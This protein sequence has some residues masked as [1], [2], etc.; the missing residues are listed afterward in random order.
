MKF[1]S[2]LGSIE[3][4]LI[5]QRNKI[6]TFNSIRVSSSTRNTSRISKKLFSPKPCY[7]LFHLSSKFVNCATFRTQNESEIN[8]AVDGHFP[9]VHSIKEIEELS[10]IVDF[11]TK[12]GLEVKLV[13]HSMCTNGP[14]NRGPS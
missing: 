4:K 8:R 6:G 5:I 14:M 10:E 7:V 13:V 9:S 1:R 12:I 3:I 2:D 11:D